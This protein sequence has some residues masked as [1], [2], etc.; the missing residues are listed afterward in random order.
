M[1][2]HEKG[3]FLHHRKND[4]SDQYSFNIPDTRIWT[5]ARV[6]FIKVE[7]NLLHLKIIQMQHNSMTSSTEVTKQTKEFVLKMTWLNLQ[8]WLISLNRCHVIHSKLCYFLL[9]NYE[10]CDGCCDNNLMIIQYTVYICKFLTDA[11]KMMLRDALLI[12][13]HTHQSR[14]QNQMITVNFK[15]FNSLRLIKVKASFE[16]DQGKCKWIRTGIEYKE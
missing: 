8:S 5:K 10:C 6:L 1:W 9:I 3:S 2:S 16:V 7:H 15:N 4:Y 12:R 13:F 11:I 14:S